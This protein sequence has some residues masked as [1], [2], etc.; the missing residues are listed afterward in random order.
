MDS[1]L[2]MPVLYTIVALA[3]PTLFGPVI[4]MATEIAHQPLSHD[5][6]SKYFV[7]LII[8]DGVLTDLQETKEALVRASDLPLSILI[9]GVGPAYFTHME[10]RDADNG[11]RLESSAGRVDTRDI[12][13]FVP[14]REVQ[15]VLLA[16]LSAC[17][18]WSLRLVEHCL[19]YRVNTNL[20]GN[21]LIA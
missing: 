7:L 13:Q 11:R 14:M 12:V 17:M 8:T 1:G 18:K 3:G 9:V 6:R 16:H 20:C 2:L 4:N 19:H 10:I 21:R 5:D 15:S